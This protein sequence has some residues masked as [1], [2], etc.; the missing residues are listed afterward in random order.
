MPEAESYDHMTYEAMNSSFARGSAE[1][2][3]DAILS[4]LQALHAAAH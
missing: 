1:R 4:K 3:A 2:I